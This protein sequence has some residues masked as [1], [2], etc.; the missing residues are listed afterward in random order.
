MSCSINIYDRHPI[1]YYRHNGTIRKE[2]ILE[3]WQE[4]LNLLIQQGIGY[5]LILDFR[6]AHFIFRPFEIDDIVNFFYL[7][8][9]ILNNRKIAGIANVPHEAAIIKLIDTLKGHEVDCQVQL[10]MALEEAFK[11]LL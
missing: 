6:E 4:V 7:S 5:N 3:A 11:Y 9:G 1:V 10:F 2:N 8:I